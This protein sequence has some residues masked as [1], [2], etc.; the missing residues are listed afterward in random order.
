MKVTEII[1][2]KIKKL[3]KN[4]NTYRTPVGE[5]DGIVGEPKIG[6][7]LVMTSS[8]HESGGVM[9]S[10]VEDVQQDETGWTIKTEF[11]TYRIDRWE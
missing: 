11:S 10:V 9:T 6:H 2:V 1:K 3:S 7:R 4:D 8:T 5:L